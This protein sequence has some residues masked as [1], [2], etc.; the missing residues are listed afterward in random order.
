M[1]RVAKGDVHQILE[2]TAATILDAD[3]GDGRVSREDIDEKVDT[4]SGNEKKLVSIFYKF[5]DHRDYGHG[6]VVTKTDVDR[7][8]TY[9]K[10]KLIDKYDLNHNGLSK[11]EIDK[12]STT[13]K[14][15]VSLAKELKAEAFRLEKNIGQDV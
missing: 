15:A 12:M 1:A 9:A 8:V 14:L 6:N 13:G 11:S 3:K 5:I 7:A 10:E 4:L 2:R